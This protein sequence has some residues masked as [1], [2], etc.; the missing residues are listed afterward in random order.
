M[1]TFEESKYLD[2][3]EVQERSCNTNKSAQHWKG[4]QSLYAVE[5]CNSI[6]KTDSVLSGFLCNFFLNNLET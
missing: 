4:K 5:S 6:P 2:P 3:G 1:H